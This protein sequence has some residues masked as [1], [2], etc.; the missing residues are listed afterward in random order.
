MADNNFWVSVIWMLWEGLKSNT[1]ATIM[2]NNVL[3][4]TGRKNFQKIGY[5]VVIL[6]RVCDYI[7]EYH[8]L[9]NIANMWISATK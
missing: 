3:V 8:Q 2:I 7:T 4:K 9:N 1:E 5:V 6:S